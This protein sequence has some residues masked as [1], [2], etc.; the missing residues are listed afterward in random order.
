MTGIFGRFSSSLADGWQLPLISS[1]AVHL[2]LLTWLLFGIQVK[3]PEVVRK[4]AQGKPV[5]AEAIDPQWAEQE[6]A[7]LDQIKIDKTEKLKAEQ[8]KVKQLQREKEKEQAARK[9]AERKKAESERLLV[10]ER[11][12][13]A[14]LLAKQEKERE[15]RAR[16]AKL[17]EKKRLQAEQARKQAEKEEKERQEKLAKE[18]KERQE[19]LA[20]EEA[21]RKEEIERQRVARERAQKELQAQFAGEQAALDKGLV[22][23]HIV[24]IQS[25]VANSWLRPLNWSTEVSCDVAVK[26]IP[27][28]EVITAQ[29][30]GSCGSAAFDRSVEAA[31]VKASPLPVP[32]DPRLFND[33]FRSFT[34]VFRNGG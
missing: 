25:R 20:K 5:I 28:G 15:E 18:E 16:Q 6:L 29:V 3:A 32:E 12:K 26:L 17:A 27:G 7:R 8:Q 1:T 30:V 10:E 34:F 2:L 33:N 24:A 21:K 4:P 19:K 23:K 11:K 13:Q 22:A 9:T 31:V 14:A